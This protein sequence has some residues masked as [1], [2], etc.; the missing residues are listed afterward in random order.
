MILTDALLVALLN[1]FRV[2]VP[3]KAKALF[4]TAYTNILI[5]FLKEFAGT[6]RCLNLCPINT[7]S[8]RTEYRR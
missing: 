8:P 7:S 2:Q 4:P 1:K 6:A 3:N 5:L